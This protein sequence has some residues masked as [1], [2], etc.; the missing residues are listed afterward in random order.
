MNSIQWISIII[1]SLF[2]LQIIYLTSKHKLQDQQAFFWIMISISSL[3][4]AIL[5]PLLNHIA[6]LLGISYMPTLIFLL[7]FIFILNI[8]M[9]QNTLL[10]KQQDKLKSLVQEVAFLKKELRDKYNMEEGKK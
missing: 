6:S 10:S 2:F 7:A 9:Y 5:I 3:I 8:L 4:I 1:A